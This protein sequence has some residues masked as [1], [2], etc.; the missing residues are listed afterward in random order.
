MRRFEGVQ[1][2]FSQDQVDTSLDL[3]GW[4]DGLPAEVSQCSQLP[5]STGHGVH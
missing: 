5:I 3:S 2:F 1:P 4:R